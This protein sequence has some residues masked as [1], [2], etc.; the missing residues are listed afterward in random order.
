MWLMTQSYFIEFDLVILFY[1]IFVN[2]YS[3]FTYLESGQLDM[4]NFAGDLLNVFVSMLVRGIFILYVFLNIGYIVT[5]SIQLV[6]DGL[7]EDRIISD[8]DIQLPRSVIEGAYINSLSQLVVEYECDL[9][10]D[11][12][13]NQEILFLGRHGLAHTARIK[14]DVSAFLRYAET[15][16]PSNQSLYT[17]GTYIALMSDLRTVLS[18]KEGINVVC[19]W[20]TNTPLEYHNLF[21]LYIAFKKTRFTTSEILRA[22]TNWKRFSLSIDYESITPLNEC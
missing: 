8:V 20:K 10:P 4:S 14:N 13:D 5:K 18:L 19:R 17:Y 7:S 3:D 2:I 12:H 1:K 15:L 16:I 21:R 11:N 9:L 6:F 22:Q